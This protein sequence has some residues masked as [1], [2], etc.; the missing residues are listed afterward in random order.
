MKLLRYGRPVG[1]V[2]DL[3]GSRE[4][5]MTYALGFV[6]SRSTAFAL[7]LAKAPGGSP[8]GSEGVVRL[9]EVEGDGRTDVELRWPKTFHGVF[10]AKRG[11]HLP[12]VGQLKKYAPKLSASNAKTKVL[13]AVTNA[14][15]AYA[16]RALPKD[17]DGVP[18]RHLTWRRIRDLARQVRPEENNR[19]KH[20]LNEFDAYLTE[21][22]GMENTRSNMVYVVSLGDGGAW[23]VDFKEIANK[24]QRYFYPTKGHWPSSPPNYIAFRYDGQPQSVHHVDEYEVFANPH[25]VFPDA[26]DHKIDPHYLLKL[27]P[28]IRPPK[29]VRTGDKIKRSMR[30]WA[31]LDLLLTCS[32]ITEARDKTKE[33]L[34]RDA[35]EMK[36]EEGD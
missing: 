20:L 34:G 15:Q 25:D 21:I 36:D 26:K 28:A 22:L 33:R 8:S 13:V 27:G 1:T 24:R 3:L 5:D 2:F 10:E 17:L 9:Q 16:E 19:N 30:V 6:A 11:P 12:T 7:A 18:V 29:E 4:D 31:M 35:D 32:T 14:T 23:G